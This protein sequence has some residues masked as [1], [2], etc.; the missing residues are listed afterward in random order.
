M[1]GVLGSPSCPLPLWRPVK[2]CVGDV[3]WLSYH[4]SDPSPS[5][6]HDD[7]A[8]AVLIAVGKKMVIGDGLC[9]ESL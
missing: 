1:P 2:G 3:A 9:P 5:P 8:H 4:M 7:G 6:L